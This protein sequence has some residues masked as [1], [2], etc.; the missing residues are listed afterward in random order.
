VGPR[1][2]G[3][4]E[5]AR[6]TTSDSLPRTVTI[7]PRWLSSCRAARAVGR[8]TLN[9]SQRP[10]RSGPHACV[11]W[12][13]EIRLPGTDRRQ[14]ETLSTSSTPFRRTDG[15]RPTTVQLSF[16]RSPYATDEP[17]DGTA[18]R[19]VRPYVIACER[20]RARRCRWRVAPVIAAD[21]GIDVDRRRNAP[22]RSRQR[23]GTCTRS[24]A[25]RRTHPCRTAWACRR[26]A[27]AVAGPPAAEGRVGNT[28]TPPNR[29]SHA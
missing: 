12:A 29:A 4:L 22:S 10:R 3:A 13:L 7:R 18:A 2:S 24:A 21:F 19:L 20:E 9:S 15:H 26:R 1:S 27:A 28:G 23:T 25:R 14:A 11:R 6:S 16:P 17:L 5:G 8:G